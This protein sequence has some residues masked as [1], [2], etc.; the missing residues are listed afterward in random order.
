M[1]PDYT[2]A[3]QRRPGPS[4]GE[5]W[6]SV[7]MSCG[8]GDNRGGQCAIDQNSYPISHMGP[9]PVILLDHVHVDIEVWAQPNHYRGVQSGS[10]E[11]QIPAFSNV[12]L[13]PP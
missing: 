5:D 6:R 2:E 3:L 9:T 11:P 7:A 13:I 1:D 12:G 8:G 4:Q 10:M